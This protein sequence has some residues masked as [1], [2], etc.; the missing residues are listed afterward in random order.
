[1]TP[2]SSIQ[3]SP[4]QWQQSSRWSESTRNH[5]ASSSFVAVPEEDEEEDE[6]TSDYPDFVPSIQPSMPQHPVHLAPIPDIAPSRPAPVSRTSSDSITKPISKSRSPLRKLTRSI[7]GKK[8]KPHSIAIPALHSV[9]APLIASAPATLDSTSSA[10]RRGSLFNSIR[11]SSSRS[12]SCSSSTTLDFAKSEPTSRKGS[13]QSSLSAAS[14]ALDSSV[15]E[16]LA[17]PHTEEVELPTPR[18]A[19][20]SSL[21]AP[22]VLTDHT[23]NASS[24]A[25]SIISSRASYGHHNNDF[26]TYQFYSQL[27]TPEFGQYAIHPPASQRSEISIPLDSASFDRRESV[28]STYSVTEEEEDSGTEV[29]VEDYSGQAFTPASPQKVGNL[30]NPWTEAVPARKSF[31]LASSEALSCGSRRASLAAAGANP[32]SLST[33][34]QFAIET[35]VPISVVSS[36][37]TSLAPSL[38]LEENVEV[39][40]ATPELKPEPIAWTPVL[41]FASYGFPPKSSSSSVAS[42]ESGRRSGSRSGRSSRRSSRRNSIVDPSPTDIPPDQSTPMHIRSER[43]GKPSLKLPVSRSSSLGRKPSL[44]V[45]FIDHIGSRPPSIRN[46]KKHQDSWASSSRTASFDSVSSRQTISS[47]SSEPEPPEMP[48]LAMSAISSYSAANPWKGYSLA[49]AFGS[50]ASMITHSIKT[51]PIPYSP[52]SGSNSMTG[53]AAGVMQKMEEDRG[54]YAKASETEGRFRVNFELSADGKFIELYEP[55]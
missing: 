53:L 51:L 31:S 32:P 9:P 52:L 14:S 45:S 19:Y 25:S 20:S 26:S 16:H 34:D 1:M 35:S 46:S 41:D 28:A 49:S 48:S 11:T 10:T 15:S 47:S 3:C 36:R 39:P 4:H 18:P 13:H 37:R 12:S 6:P 40:E 24:F 44:S 55:I 38:I 2:E 27:P 23:D 22:S 50:A 7:R 17:L 21:S 33:F 54:R 8:A 43:Q 42:S 30:V 29:T 5:S